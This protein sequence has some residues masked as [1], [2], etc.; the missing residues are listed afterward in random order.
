[1][2]NYT[3][4]NRALVHTLPFCIFFAC[5][6]RANEKSGLEVRATALRGRESNEPRDDGAAA[7]RLTRVTKHPSCA[8]VLV[9]TRSL[10]LEMPVWS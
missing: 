6:S 5:P 10:C 7:R 1:M 3:L 4:W 8:F 9:W 2:T